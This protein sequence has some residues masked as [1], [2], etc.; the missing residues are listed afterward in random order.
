MSCQSFA[1]LNQR[2]QQRETVKRIRQIAVSAVI[3]QQSR[4]GTNQQTGNDCAHP[5]IRAADNG[6]AIQE[7][8]LAGRK[9]GVVELTVQTGEQTTSQTGDSAAECKRPGLVAKHGHTGCNGCGFTLAN[10]RPCTTGHGG[11]LPFDEGHAGCQPEHHITE[12]SIVTSGHPW[13]LYQCALAIDNAASPAFAAIRKTD[14]V[15]DYLKRSSDHQCQQRQIQTTHAQRRQ[16]DDQ[17]EQAGND[18][19]DEQ[20]Y[21]KRQAEAMNQSQAEPATN[22][23]QCKLR[24][25]HH[26]KLTVQQRHRRGH[27]S[28]ARHRAEGVE[29]V[30]R[31]QR[32]SDHGHHKKGDKHRA[33]A[34][35]RRAGRNIGFVFVSCHDFYSR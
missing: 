7:N 5:V 35:K 9:T 28:Q 14:D 10:Q 25:R 32:R 24:Q 31:E 13:P 8:R 12:I 15:D 11:A 26:A 20:R 3:I 6:Q 34:L 22:T 19:T 18:G 16:P 27:Q 1:A 2:H 33:H 23:S 29:P 30:G 4:Q 17:T 21:F